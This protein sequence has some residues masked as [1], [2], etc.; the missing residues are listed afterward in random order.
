MYVIYP[1]ISTAQYSIG[2]YEIMSGIA[3]NRTDVHNRT[4]VALIARMY[5]CDSLDYR[6]LN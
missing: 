4:Q 6:V 2:V 5:T 3:H 1:T